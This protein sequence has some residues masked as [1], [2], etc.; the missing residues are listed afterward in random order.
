M[1]QA[2]SGGGRL[3]FQD[4]PHHRRKAVEVLTVEN[5]MAGGLEGLYIRVS[6]PEVGSS[7]SPP[8]TLSRSIDRLSQR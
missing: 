8:S 7:G 5:R 4:P 6:N 1:E 2:C 3:P